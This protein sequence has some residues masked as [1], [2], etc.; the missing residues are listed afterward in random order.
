MSIYMM[1][2]ININMCLLVIYVYVY[3]TYKG[4]DSS[5]GIATR[6]RLQGPRIESQWRRDFPNFPD[7]P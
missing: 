2:F 3:I 4:R 6:Y 5:I 7:R 1:Q